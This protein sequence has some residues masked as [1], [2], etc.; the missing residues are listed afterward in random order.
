MDRIKKLEDRVKDLEQDIVDLSKITDHIE[1]ETK[2]PADTLWRCSKC[3]L[4]LGVYDPKED[5]LRVRYK[6][7]YAY[8]RAGKG[9]FCRII[10]R[11]C[12]HIN[13]LQY[14]DK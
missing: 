3:N 5:I 6:D 14:I 12:S 13:E 1:D 10:C 2:S 8:Y 11:S 9:G 7:F 4:R